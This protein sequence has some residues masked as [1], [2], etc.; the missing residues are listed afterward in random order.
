MIKVHVQIT[1]NLNLRTKSFDNYIVRFTFHHRKTLQR[2]NHWLSS[3]ISSFHK[4]CQF[5]QSNNTAFHVFS[6]LKQFQI[7]YDVHITLS[8]SNYTWIIYDSYSML[9]FSNFLIWTFSEQSNTTPVWTKN[10]TILL[11]VIACH[12]LYT[13][14]YTYSFK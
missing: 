9:F 3:N 4:S 8:P 1:R 7:P 12:Y 11:I 5:F 14:T 2:K 13:Y 10:N 6:S